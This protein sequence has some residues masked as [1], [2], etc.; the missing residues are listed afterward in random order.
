MKVSAPI[1]R[2]QAA[3][4][5][6]V[7]PAAHRPDAMLRSEATG[8]LD[9]VLEML[10]WRIAGRVM[11]MKRP[12]PAGQEDGDTVPGCPESEVGVLASIPRETFIETVKAV[13][14]RRL[15]SEGE[16]PE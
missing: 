1:A 12:H 8:V 9:D 5:K 2:D 10:K 14:K 13:E 11:L 7:E 16:R 6:G 3:L 4:S 15:H